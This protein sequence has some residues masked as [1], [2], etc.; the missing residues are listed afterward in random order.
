MHVGARVHS[1]SKQ[2][3]TV[4]TIVEAERKRSRRQGLACLVVFYGAHIGR[5]IILEDE[6]ITIG[7][8]ESANIQVD[9]DSV[10][11]QHARLVTIGGRIV[12]HDLG[13][14]NGT[15][16]NDD[17]IEQSELKDGDLVRI[18]QTIF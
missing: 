11:R 7:R 9:Q 10:S 16:V 2:T 6:E 14:T 3:E 13:S 4:V 1:M 8:S 5:R 18:G 17:L 15:F 12:L